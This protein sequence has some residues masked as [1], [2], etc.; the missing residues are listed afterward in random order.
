[1]AITIDTKRSQSVGAQSGQNVF[2]CYQCKK[3]TAGCPMADHFDLSP[4]QLVRALQFG[5]VDRVLHSRTMWLCA[6]CETCVTRCPVE[7]DIPRIMDALKGIAIAQGIK[8][9]E[10]ILS[11][12]NDAAVAWMKRSGRIHDIGLMLEVNLRL[13]KPFR[14]AG[15]GVR[16]LRNG[17]I[18]FLPEWPGQPRQL[19]KPAPKHGNARR[20]GYFPGCSLHCTGSEYDESVRAVAPLIDLELAEIKDW[21]CC[22]SGAAHQVSRDLATELPMK[23]LAL[24]EAAGEDEVALPCAACYSHFKTAAHD[25]ATD[26]DL[27]TRVARRLGYDFA[28]GVKIKNIVDTF[29]ERVGLDE[30]ERRVT[31]PL[32]GLKA[33]CYYGCLLTRPVQVTKAAELEYPMSMDRIVR[34]LGAETIDWSYKTECCGASLM[35]TQ[36]DR[37]LPLAER[38]LANAKAVGADAVVVGCSF[39]HLNLDMRQRDIAER[40]GKRY[41]IPVLYFT[42]LMGLAFGLSPKELG[43]AKHFAKADGLLQRLHLG[44]A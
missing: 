43:L 10:P 9:P 5:Q 15:V 1:M 39:C 25:M 16:M 30:I 27:H 6:Y 17:K 40:L 4:A 42:Q 11:A 29:T 28:G 2:L 23:N 7:L 20:V 8:A 31:R 33:V 38:I 26:A 12:F 44:G 13:G 21:V 3:C 32:K 14:D 34:R 37:A 19:P 22:G 18:R 36:T 35:I 41:D 24:A